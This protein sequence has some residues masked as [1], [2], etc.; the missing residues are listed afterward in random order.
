[1]AELVEALEPGIDEPPEAVRAVM[2]SGVQITE[3]GLPLDLGIEQLHEHVELAPVPG[4]VAFEE[5]TYVVLGHCLRLRKTD[6]RP[7]PTSVLK[8]LAHDRSPGGGDL[9][10][11]AHG[12]GVRRRLR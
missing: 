1:D 7:S 9:V 10:Q 3:S 5:D 2:D 6:A 12:G 8:R 11:P 4:L